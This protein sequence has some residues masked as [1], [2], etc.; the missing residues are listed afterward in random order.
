MEKFFKKN[1]LWIVITIVSLIVLVTIYYRGK[2][3]GKGVHLKKLNKDIIGAELSESQ[4]NILKSL[5][6]KLHEDIH[7]FFCFRNED[8]YKQVS[9]LSNNQLGALNNIYNEFYEVDDSETFYQALDNEV[10]E[11][12]SFQLAGIVSAILS[13]LN[14]IN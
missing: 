4:I 1:W 7:C 2:K 8:L 12:S 6:E 11:N 10:M 5:A 3:A 9:N 13:R 14:T